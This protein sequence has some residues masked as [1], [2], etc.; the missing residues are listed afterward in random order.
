[1]KMT[2]EIQVIGPAPAS[3]AKAND[4]YRRV[5]YAKHKNMIY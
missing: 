4:T 1:M 5:I 3:L 2:P